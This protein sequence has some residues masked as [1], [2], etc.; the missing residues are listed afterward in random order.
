M[1]GQLRLGPLEHKFL[2][3]LELLRRSL[4]KQILL[5]G[6]FEVN[7]DHPQHL[8]AVDSAST[9][10]GFNKFDGKVQ[11]SSECDAVQKPQKV[12][13][14]LIKLGPLQAKAKSVQ[15]HAVKGLIQQA[16]PI[17]EFRELVHQRVE[18]FQIPFTNTA[19]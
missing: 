6:F 15:I 4:L 12:L 16:F 9:L 8:R 5:L 11:R 18:L 2:R 14:V 7:Y 19:T 3:F 10:V 13:F 1:F 17:C